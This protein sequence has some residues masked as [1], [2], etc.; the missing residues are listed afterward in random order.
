[1]RV[2]CCP[3]LGALLTMALAALS[4]TALGVLAAGAQDAT[5]IG[6]NAGDASEWVEPNNWTPITVPSGT[7]TFTNTG[8]ATVANDNGIVAIGAIDFTGTPNAQAYTINI[9]NPF[10]LNGAGVTNNSTNN[11]TF[12]VTSGNALVFQNSSTA[13]NGAGSVTYNNDGGGFIDFNNSSNA[14]NANTTINN[15]SILQFNDGS[16]AGSAQITNNVEMDFFDST[17][18]SSANITNASTGTLTFNNSATAGAAIIGNAG[19]IQF[20]NSSNAGSASITNGGSGATIT[21]N[22][23]SSAGSATINT[24]NSNVAI[25]FNDSSSAGTATFTSNPSTFV[26]YTF[27]NTGTAASANFQLVDATLTFN[28]S[29]SAGSATLNMPNVMHP[30]NITFNDTSTAGNA[31]IT[32]VAVTTLGTSV[33]FLGASTAGNATITN[34]PNTAVPGEGGVLYFGALS[35]TDTANAG[36]AIIVNNDF[37]STSF[38]AHTSASSA[39]IT[40][41]TGGSTNFQDESTAANATIVNSGGTTTFGVPT[42]GTDTATAG[43][44]NITNNGGG[45][46]QFNAF[47]TAGS[48]V[49]TTNSGGLVAFADSSTGGNA[50][51][52]TNA[53]GVFNMSGLT[54]GAMTAG[55]IAGAGNYVLGGNAL[56]VGSNNLSTTVSGVISGAGGSLIKVGTGTLTL[57]NTETYTGATT[58]DGGT[59]AVNGSIASSTVTVNSGGTLTGTGI[60]DPVVVTI[61]SGGTLAPGAMGVPG[62]SM[63]IAGN[64]VFQSGATYAISLNPTTSTLANVTGTASLAGTVNA[65]FAAGTYG[66]KQYTILTSAGLGGTTFSG[67]TTN[68]PGFNSTLSYNADDVFLNLSASLGQSSALNVNQQNVAT[69]LNNFFNSGGAVPPGFMSVFGL[70]GANLANALT[71]L[72]GEDAT[73]AERGAF[74]L[75]NEFLG[76]MLDPFVYGRDGNGGGPA[77]GFAPDRQASLPPDIALAY[78]GLL[79]APPPQAFDRR[80]TAWASGFGGSNQTNRDPTIGSTDVTTG[81]Y[82]YAAGMDYHYSPDTVVG[83]ALAG[84][85]TNWNLAQALGTGR[86]DAVLAGV[87][88][89]THAGPVY[90]AGALAF[91]NN[92]FTTDRAALGDQ[93]TANFQGQSYGGRLEAGYRFAAPGSYGPAGITPYAA[94][95]AQDFHTPSYSESDLSGGGLGLSYN[96]MSGTDT[97]SELGGRFDDLIVLNNMPLMLRAKVAWAHDWVSNP[98]LNASFQSLPGTSFTVFGAPIPHNSALTS[99][100]AQL[101]FTPNWSLIAKF[102]GEFAQGAQTYGGSATLRYDW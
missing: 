90:L 56:T 70:S 73:G 58:V 61:N 38:L 102:D 78:A 15:F 20:N 10:I 69:A 85:G 55:S 87:H 25:T 95:Q 57:T 84:G 32:N 28:N 7:A 99:A 6:G 67:L 35:G 3:S 82:G 33:Q 97:R 80:W 40:N 39:M 51:F 44:A 24:T 30:A 65:N 86:S 59:L 31:N 83:F 5:W 36:T 60:I 88:A 12:N 8:V 71:Q 63:S 29:S 64:L 27:N 46:T 98:A 89:V 13:N 2:A 49:I 43:N 96:A 62:T 4:V 92:W 77:L 53:G 9:D 42:V 34:N 68:M 18:A 14:G 74:Q 100:G 91:A 22:N 50:Q 47:T 41:N 93:L 101:F 52:I 45:T 66:K 54:D 11:Q 23:S 17:T 94:L 21:F 76:L 19:A 48:A 81:T 72:D 79:K 75:M 37:G 26:A 16:S 1:M